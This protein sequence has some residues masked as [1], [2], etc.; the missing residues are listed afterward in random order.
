GFEVGDF[1]ADKYLS[2]AGKRRR[3]YI[4]TIKAFNELMANICR[5]K[6]SSDYY[7]HPK[8]EQNYGIQNFWKNRT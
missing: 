8:W 1:L 6:T 5:Q 7:C 2:A 3:L 4:N